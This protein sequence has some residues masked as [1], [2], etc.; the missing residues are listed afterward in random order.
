MRVNLFTEID[1]S[2]QISEDSRLKVPQIQIIKDLKQ[3]ST[4]S[5][6][7][8]PRFI[9]KNLITAAE[10]H[11]FIHGIEYQSTYVGDRKP[12]QRN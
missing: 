3:N 1:F 4:S 9:I 6:V 11:R 7:Y 2:L 12:Q 8:Y 5:Q 10:F